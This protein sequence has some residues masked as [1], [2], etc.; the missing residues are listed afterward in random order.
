MDA[1]RRAINANGCKCLIWCCPL[2]AERLFKMAREAEGSVDFDFTSDHDA[3]SM[4]I[5]KGATPMLVKLLS[6]DDNDTVRKNIAVL[7][8][9]LARKHEGMKEL[10]ACGGLRILM[11]IGAKS[12]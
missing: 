12:K 2:D 4:I 1:D 10:K 3:S 7:L 6:I 11:E 5:G 9:R 8:A